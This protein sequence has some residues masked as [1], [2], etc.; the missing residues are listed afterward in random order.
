MNINGIP[1][2]VPGLLHEHALSWIT[3]NYEDI[4]IN[5]HR[6]FMYQDTLATTW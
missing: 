3:E 6:I 2:I 1:Y 4:Y 5:W